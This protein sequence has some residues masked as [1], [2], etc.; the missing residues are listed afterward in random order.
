M[1]TTQSSKP[2]LFAIAAFVLAVVTAMVMTPPP[3][4]AGGEPIVVIVNVANPVDNLAMGDLKKIVLSEH[5]R[6]D[7]GKA[8]APVMVTAGAPERTAF[9]KIVCGMNDADF[10]K[11]FLQAA[12]AGKSATPPKEVGG[13]QGVK[14]TVAGSPGAIGFVKAAD[15]HGD[16]SDGGVKAVKIDGMAASDDGYKLRM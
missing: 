7:T 13:P 9:L 15:F 11:Y 16:G 4:R 6:W 12:F 2:L 3:V 14:S 10:G 8:V 5:S 1:K